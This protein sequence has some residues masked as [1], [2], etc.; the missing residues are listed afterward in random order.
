MVAVL[1]PAPYKPRTSK[2]RRER[3][4]KE[5]NERIGDPEAG[6]SP[7]RKRLTA[8]RQ[9]V[10]RC[11]GELA[12]SGALKVGMIRERTGVER[13]GTILRDNHYG[14]FERVKRGHYELSPRGHRE[15][16]DWSEALEGLDPR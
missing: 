10:L 12:G 13:A 3:L 4:L 6:G 8:Y 5:F 15:L 16:A 2:K 7:S 14:W 1:D 9:D 11:A